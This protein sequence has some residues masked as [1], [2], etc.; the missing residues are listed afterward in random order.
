MNAP[1]LT[2]AVK[3]DLP[4]PK[5]NRQKRLALRFTVLVAAVCA[6]GAAYWFTRPP[7]LVW[8][9][10]D[11][12]RGFNHSV[13]LQVPNGWEVAAFMPAYDSEEMKRFGYVLMVAVD[14]R[15]ELIRRLLPDKETECYLIVEAH[16]FSFPP[17]SPPR[18]RILGPSE[19][20]IS[21][22][23]VRTDLSMWVQLTYIR[24]D[25]AAFRRTYRQ[26]CNSLRIE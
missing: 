17:P 23:L 7:E 24:S 3:T 15:P 6:L 21:K 14:R 19:Y 26:I 25:N 18:P 16:D 13:K 12:M 4:S 22:E 11:T 5:P 2:G 1:A 9:R 10:S 20:C 8:W